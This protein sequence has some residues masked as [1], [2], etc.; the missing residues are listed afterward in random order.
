[1]ADLIY[2][3]HAGTT[4][5]D[6]E[7]VKAM[8]PYFDSKFGNA[9]TLYSLGT[10]AREAV[11]KARAQVASLIGARPEH[12]FFTG[13]GTEADNWALIGIPH[14]LAGKG[15]H[16]VTTPIEHSAIMAS[17]RFLEKHGF[18]V[19][20]L[21]VDR[22]GLKARF[23]RKHKKDVATFYRGIERRKLVSD[24]AQY[25]RDRLVKYRE[26]LFTFLEHDGIPWNNN[27]A[28][29]AIKPFAKY[30]RLAM[31]S[32]TPKG[33]DAYLVLLSIYQTCEYRGVSFLDFLLSKERDIDRYCRSVW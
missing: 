11:E 6:P 8:K 3:D 29:H 14:A 12:I 5:P 16:I 20:Y 24:V 22:Y 10:Q 32:M 4:K 1:M 18:R 33:L 2:M 31:R 7:V 27:N 13:S 28:E 17:C 30:R 19:T 25:Y 15:D 9:S 26:K 23:L 21:P